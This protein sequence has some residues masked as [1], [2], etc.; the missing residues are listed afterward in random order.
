MSKVDS[1]PRTGTTIRMTREEQARVKALL[2]R[3][4]LDRPLKAKYYTMNDLFRDLVHTKYRE[5]FGVAVQQFSG[6][7]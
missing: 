6:S 3:E 7:D 4:N 1:I 5:V 2:D